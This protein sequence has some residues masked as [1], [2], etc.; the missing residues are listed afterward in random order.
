M[1]GEREGQ[2]PCV[3]DA[4]PAADEWRPVE[5]PRRPQGQV[6]VQ[7]DGVGEPRAE[8]VGVHPAKRVPR[9][10]P[11]HPQLEVGLEPRVPVVAVAPRVPPVVVAVEVE[12]EREPAVGA[13]RDGHAGGGRAP[14]GGGQEENVLLQPGVV[15]YRPPQ[16]FPLLRLGRFPEL[17][18]LAPRRTPEL[19]PLPES[20][21]TH[22]FSLSAQDRP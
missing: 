6:P 22:T 15:E 2:A 16:P 19:P 1:P 20:K 10:Q 21:G 11:E 17:P 18:A 4:S 3:R 13:G 9:R 8:G 12:G 7:A 5:A 14:G